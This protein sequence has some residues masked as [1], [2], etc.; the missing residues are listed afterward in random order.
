M[1]TPKPLVPPK[2]LPKLP[3][4]SASWRKKTFPLG[5][6]DPPVLAGEGWARVKGGKVH[7]ASGAQQTQS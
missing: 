3:L 4:C 7:I 2:L 6:A 1:P 5:F